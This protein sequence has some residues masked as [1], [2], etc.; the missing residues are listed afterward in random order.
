MCECGCEVV[1]SH[2]DTGLVTPWLITSTCL[3][4]CDALNAASLLSPC[5]GPDPGASPCPGA[6]PEPSPEPS[7]CFCVSGPGC[8]R[9]FPGDRP[10]PSPGADRAGGGGLRGW[11]PSAG[12][13][14]W[15]LWKGGSTLWIRSPS[16]TNLTEE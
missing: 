13:N 7:P 12:G 5:P 11:V 3:T 9:K 6:S 15:S 2:R 8:I 14:N 4:T 16:I 1:P 10:S